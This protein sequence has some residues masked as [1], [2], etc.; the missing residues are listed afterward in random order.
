MNMARSLPV[1]RTKPCLKPSE[2][3]SWFA[4]REELTPHVERIFVEESRK[5]N[6]PSKDACRTVA[7]ALMV[8][9]ARV[10]AVRQD[11]LTPSIQRAHKSAMALH[12]HLQPLRQR[13]AD[14]F[15]E[16]EAMGLEA[17]GLDAEPLNAELT[18]LDAAVEAVEALVPALDRLAPWPDRD[19][20][21]F[22][23][24]KVREAWAEANNGR[25]PKSKDAGGPLVNVVTRLLALVLKKQKPET[26]SA[27]LK[28]RRGNFQSWDKFRG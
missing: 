24:E 21:L 27:R 17:I 16:L 9:R 13:L 15:Y 3:R 14:R 7:S 22:I 4:E 1:A 10:T 19:P 20:S 8:V 12:H 5:H 2:S 23:A 28:L 18:L 26:V 25:S 11:T 6:A